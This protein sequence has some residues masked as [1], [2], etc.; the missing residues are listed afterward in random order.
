MSHTDNY[1]AQSHQPSRS[2]PRGIPSP[3]FKSSNCQ[4]EHCSG[5]GPCTSLFLH[6]V[7]TSEDFFM[8]HHETF[9]KLQWATIYSECRSLRN[10]VYYLIL[11]IKWSSFRITHFNWNQNVDSTRFIW[12]NWEHPGK[13]SLSQTNRCLCPIWWRRILTQSRAHC[14]LFQLLNKRQNY[15]CPQHWP[16]LLEREVTSKSQSPPVTQY[17]WTRLQQWL[18]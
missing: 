7:K 2:T 8:I 9:M 15:C 10:T 1:A 14:V 12:S 11:P 13:Q 5:P 18:H 16:K 3:G 4:R 6:R 17:P